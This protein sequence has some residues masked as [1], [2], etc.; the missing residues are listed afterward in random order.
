MYCH[1]LF[2]FDKFR[3]LL[4]ADT[5]PVLCRTFDACIASVVLACG[6]HAWVGAGLIPAV[7]SYWTLLQ[8]YHCSIF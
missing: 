5:R 6:G 3:L 4:F 2:G 8:Y 7:F 1:H